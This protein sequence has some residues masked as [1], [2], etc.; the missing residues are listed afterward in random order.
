MSGKCRQSKHEALDKP[1]HGR[2]VTREETRRSPDRFSP[3]HRGVAAIGGS[4]CH[5]TGTEIDLD[6][7][8]GRHFDRHAGVLRPHTNRQ[9]VQAVYDNLDRM[10]ATDVFLDNLGA[11]S[12]NATLD[13]FAKEGADA[14]NKIAVF[15]Q[16][17]DSATLS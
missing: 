7:G 14:P 17:M 9:P 6:P 13:G 10:R 5:G 11:V 1:Y 16:L 2:Q 12:I 3:C 8:Q 15:E 4:G